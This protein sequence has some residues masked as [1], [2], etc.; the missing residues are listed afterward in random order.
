M[1]GRL[2]RSVMDRA[3]RAQRMARRF[4]PLP[5]DLA[6]A[7]NGFF[8]ALGEPPSK[9]VQPERARFLLRLLDRYR[10]RRIVELGS[11]VSTTWFSWWATKHGAEFYSLEQNPRWAA[12]VQS[13]APR[14]NIIVSDVVTV[15][16]NERRY[17]ADMPAGADFVYIDGPGGHL[18][19]G[20]KGV[21]TDIRAY[22]ERG[23][24][25]RVIVLDGRVLTTDLIRPLAPGYRFFPDFAYCFA[26]DDLIGALRFRT[27]SYFEKVGTG[28][29]Q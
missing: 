11:G 3:D 24:R 7:A 19:Q 5:P 20:V 10:P 6:R 28:R 26:H 16:P 22:L 1:F 2:C 25:P 15:P 18:P 4:R 21:N 29:P 13:A 23:E 17:A 8:E 12:A 9:L 14:A 27:Q